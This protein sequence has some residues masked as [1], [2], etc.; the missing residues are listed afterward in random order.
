MYLAT[1]ALH[2]LAVVLFLGNIITGLVW[3]AHGDRTADRRIIGD[4]LQGSFRSD[5]WFPLPGVPLIIGFGISAADRPA[6]A[7]GHRLDPVRGYPI[8]SLGAGIHAAGRAAG[9][10]GEPWP[11]GRRWPPWS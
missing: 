11:S 10:S 1:K 9:S 4:P 8:R 7:A 2:A 3:K 6:P 5:R